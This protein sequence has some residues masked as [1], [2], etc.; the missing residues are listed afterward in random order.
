MFKYTYGNISV[1]LSNEVTLWYGN[2]DYFFPFPIFI[3][4]FQQY[5]IRFQ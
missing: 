1:I 3:L 5:H 2:H 4:I